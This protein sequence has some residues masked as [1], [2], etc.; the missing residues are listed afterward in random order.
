MFSF[1]PL[2]YKKLVGREYALRFSAVAFLAVSILGVLAI[3]LLIPYVSFVN[4]QDA[5]SAAR[6]AS[7]SSSSETV[8]AQSFRASLNTLRAESTRLAPP[9]AVLPYELVTTLDSLVTSGIQLT[10]LK[11]TLNSDGSASLSLSGMATTRESLQAFVASL[12][13]APDFTGVSV[14]VS[15]FAQDKDIDFNLQ[16]TILY[17]PSH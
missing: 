15:D 14:P 11:Y 16:M 2:Q 17:E 6:L 1:L 13:A 5:I 12:Q 7:L 9:Q 8:Q 3:L 4:S 10:A